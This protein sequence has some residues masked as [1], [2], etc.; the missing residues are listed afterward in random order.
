M[1]R[2][3]SMSETF[4]K[5]D[6]WNKRFSEHGHT[7][8]N[9]KVVYK[10]DQ[11]SRLRHIKRH[12]KWPRK[13]PLKVLDLGCGTGDFSNLVVE[14][15]PNSK[16]LGIDISNECIATNKPHPRITYENT[17]IDKIRSLHDN[18]DLIISIT[19]LQHQ[20]NTQEN[21]QIIFDLLAS[22]GTL[23]VLECFNENINE[24]YITGL[25][26]DNFLKIAKKIGFQVERRSHHN[27]LFIYLIEKIASTKR[28]KKVETEP[29]RNIS[30][31]EINFKVILYHLLGF[32]CRILGDLG[33]YKVSYITLS[34]K[35]P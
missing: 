32:I 5:Q 25:K 13:K 29:N 26:L 23:I 19:Y 34:L 35:K 12:L 2:E 11:N 4:D 17:T 22:G 31:K 3:F 8:W 21:L 9:N 6:Y 28:D 14:N 10:Y 18:W 16:V 20:K 1:E 7:G 30:T 24:K 27:Q 15:F 33:F